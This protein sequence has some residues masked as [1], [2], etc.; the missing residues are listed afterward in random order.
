MNKEKCP[1]CGYPTLD[2]RGDY[3]IC[4]LCDW[5]DDGQDSDQATEVWGGPNGDYSLEEARNNFLKNF[6]MYQ[7]HTDNNS[8]EKFRRKKELMKAYEKLDLDQ[9][10]NDSGKW[11]DILVL[12]KKL[13]LFQST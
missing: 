5:E 3:E 2:V 9:V 10:M 1:C 7:D 13:K 4:L 11:T 8:L 12:E 6:V